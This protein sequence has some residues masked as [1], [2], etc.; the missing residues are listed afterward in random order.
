MI[1]GVGLFPF[2]EAVEV[3][4]GDR[5]QLR[6]DADLVEDGY[7]WRWDT[8]FFAQDDLKAQ[9]KQSTFYGVP[10]SEGILRKSTQI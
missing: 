1:Y 2:S 5:V 6:L 9:F 7:I 8:D 4:E 10:L 3:M